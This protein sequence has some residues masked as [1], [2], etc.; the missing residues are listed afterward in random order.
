MSNRKRPKTAA[1]PISWLQLGKLPKDSA[2]VQAL[3]DR[4]EQK[5]G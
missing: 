5:L 3:L 1:P 4:T 2:E